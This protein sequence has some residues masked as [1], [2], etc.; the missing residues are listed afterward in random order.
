MEEHPAMNKEVRYKQTLAFFS[1]VAVVTV[2]G[3]VWPVLFYEGSAIGKLLSRKY[4]VEAVGDADF[5]KTMEAELYGGTRE[6]PSSSPQIGLC[7]PSLKGSSRLMKS[8][9]RWL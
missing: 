5:E 6:S 3:G 8:A 4:E 7:E 9:T 1:I 2:L